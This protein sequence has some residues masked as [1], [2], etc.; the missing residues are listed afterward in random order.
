LGREVANLVN[1]SIE[2]GRQEISFRADML[3]TGVY[4]V[5]LTHGT[6][7]NI[8]KITCLK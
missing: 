8:Q 2:A 5:R 1:N 6:N 7:V 4:F 3:S